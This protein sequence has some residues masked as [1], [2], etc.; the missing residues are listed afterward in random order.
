MTLKFVMFKNVQR[1]FA[2]F[3]WETNEKNTELS[4]TLLRVEKWHVRQINA[5]FAVHTGDFW[6]EFV[7]SP[8]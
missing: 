1:G 7:Q 2:V 5:T 4:G 6:P 3:F 8:D